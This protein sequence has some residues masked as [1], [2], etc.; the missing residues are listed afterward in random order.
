MSKPRTLPLCRG[1][2]LGGGGARGAPRG[3]TIHL[4]SPMAKGATSW[5]RS[6]AE[7][8]REGTVVLRYQAQSNAP[9]GNVAGPLQPGGQKRSGV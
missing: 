4:R 7:L 2:Y 6:L 3:E 1:G 8:V 9:I 5:S